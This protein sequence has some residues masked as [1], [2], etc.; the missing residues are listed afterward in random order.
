M[1]RRLKYYIDSLSSLFG[2]IAAW[3]CLIL[4]LLTVYDVVLRY[5]FHA[6]SVAV[7]ESEWHLFGLIILLGAAKTYQQD[8]HVRVDVFYGRFSSKTQALVGILGSVFFLLPFCA[9]VIWSSFN[10]AEAAFSLG[11]HSPDPGGLPYRFLIKAAIPFG[12]ILLML[13]AI[14]NLL[15]AIESYRAPQEL[16]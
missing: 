16:Q 15:R 11:E 6:G 4:V 1:I 12:F 5:F 9:L 7:Q 13:Q 14:A 2:S 10:F 8:E 3:L